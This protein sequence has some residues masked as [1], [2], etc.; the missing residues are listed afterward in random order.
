M[1]L[2]EGGAQVREAQAARQA[3]AAGS[4]G[5]DFNPG[6]HPRP[7]GQV[8]KVE[9]E[10]GGGGADR[11]GR[12]CRA[13]RVQDAPKHQGEEG[14]G[15]PRGGSAQAG[16]E[17]EEDV[18]GVA[19]AG[20]KV[21]GGWADK[22]RKVNTSRNGRSLA[23]GTSAYHPLSLATHSPQNANMDTGLAGA[24]AES[25]DARRSPLAAGA[26]AAAAA[27][28]VPALEGGP[29][30][31]TMTRSRLWS[32]TEGSGDMVAGVW[33]CRRVDR[34]GKKTSRE[35][36]DVAHTLASLCVG[37]SSARPLPLLLT[38]TLP[39]SFLVTTHTFS[40][41]HHHT[42]GGHARRRGKTPKW[43]APSPAPARDRETERLV[44]AALD[45]EPVSGMV[46]VCRRRVPMPCVGG[47]ERPSTRTIVH[48]PSSLPPRS[49]AK[50]CASWPSCAA[51]APT[52]CA[53]GRGPCCWGR[54]QGAT[55]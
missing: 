31:G 50:P 52:P 1:L 51:W 47:G 14:E 35:C 44:A 8:Q 6:S 25:G 33:L 36:L 27:G 38:L 55:T 43:D 9:G 15:G 23:A 28:V 39:T 11:V 18:D 34:G 16:E 5:R 7:D 19:E 40:L 24:V 4:T 22:K 53:P 45:E 30:G 3:G 41:H 49:T 17:E 46:C 10:G 20:R 32:S 29:G 12:A 48:A 26:A 54:G 21:W 37:E 13:E 2:F 42:M